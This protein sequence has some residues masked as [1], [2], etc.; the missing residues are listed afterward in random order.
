MVMSEKEHAIAVGLVIE[1]WRARYVALEKQIQ[2]ERDRGAREFAEKLKIYLEK[3]YGFDWLNDEIDGL[4][5]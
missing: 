2:F 1:K 3:N 5:K 4:L